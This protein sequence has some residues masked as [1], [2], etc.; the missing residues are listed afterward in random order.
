MPK[1]NVRKKAP[2]KQ[3]P[4]SNLPS[5]HIVGVLMVV[6]ILFFTYQYRAYIISFLASKNVI[7]KQDE[8]AT[9]R[10]EKVLHNHKE[11]AFGIDVSQYQG[12]IDWTE[13]KKTQEKFPLCFV[14]IRATAGNNKIDHKFKKNWTEAKKNN[15][16]CGA[17]H[18]YRPN[19]NSI[20][21]A[22]NFIKT[23]K[24]R[25]GD[26]PPVLDIEQLPDNQSM[27][28]L[29]KGLQKWLD[30][31]ENHYGIQPIIYSSE[32]YYEDFLKKEFSN[33][34]FWVAN[35]NN[36]VQTMDEDW[37]FW[38]FTEKAAIPGIS[39]KVDLNVYNGT[40]KMLQYLT[41]SN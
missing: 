7:Y 12:V 34:T 23:V 14:F 6:V 22:N 38:Q 5:P 18:Y 28:N 30:K 41:F 16:I 24:L 1:T 10:I 33:Y 21:Q 17:Y 40:P 39:E 31:V 29:K 25:K 2:K 19:E 27:E 4:K 3:K 26:L 15:Y 20:E 13:T 11:R 35:Y 37:T 8:V 32:K 36:W 9:Q